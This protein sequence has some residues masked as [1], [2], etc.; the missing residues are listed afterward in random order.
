MRSFFFI[1]VVAAVIALGAYT[2]LELSSKPEPASGSWGRGGAMSVAVET[3]SSESFVDIVEAL[4]T[5][6]AIESVNV[7][8][9]VSDIIAQV[10]FDSGDRVKKGDI[11]V[12]LSSGEES[13]EIAEAR[14]TLDEARREEQRIAELVQRGVA[15][16]QRLDEAVARR[17]RADARISSLNARLADRTIRAPFAGVIGLRNVS[18]GQLI[19]PGDVIATLDQLE[20]VDVDFTVPEQFLS[21]LKV[22]MAISATSSAYENR[23]FDGVVVQIGSR[24]DP[25]TRSVTVRAT[26]PN[27]D[28]SL[29]PG[30]LLS[31]ELQRNQRESVSIPALALSRRGDEAFV[32]VIA[33]GERAMM[34]QERIVTIGKRMPDRLE[35]LSGLEPGERVVSKGV[36]RVRAGM[37]VTIEGEAPAIASPKA[38]GAARGAAP[39][40]G[41]P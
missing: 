27:D 10:R 1:F 24:V 5:V 41:R 20:A 37:P 2:F 26:L 35:V 22:G 28:V 16:R 8:A 13:A 11:L 9:G 12:K 7:T 15:A 32:F 25:V 21:V 18:L 29:L 14:A 17:E 36:H 31:V 3:V 4:G 6:R 30:M 40:S 34:A 23:S 33:Q 19:R 39:A 38:P